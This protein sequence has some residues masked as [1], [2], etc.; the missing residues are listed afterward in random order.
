[1]T[2]ILGRMAAYKHADVTWDEMMNSQERF[3]PNLRGLKA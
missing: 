2:T 3:E 1:L